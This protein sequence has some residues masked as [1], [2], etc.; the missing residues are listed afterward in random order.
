MFVICKNKSNRCGNA[1]IEVAALGR[2][3]QKQRA[4]WQETLNALASRYTSPTQIYGCTWVLA[5]WMHARENNA[6]LYPWN[7]RTPRQASGLLT[8]LRRLVYEQV[9]VRR[10]RLTT[11]TNRWLNFL[12]AAKQ[13]ATLGSFP[14][15]EWSSP[16][17]RG[18]PMVNGVD[19]RSRATEGTIACEQQLPVS[20]RVE[21]DN[22]HSAL[23]VPVSITASD[24]DY[25]SEYETD[26]ASAIEHFKCAA[27]RE[28]RHLQKKTALGKRFIEV[29]PFSNLRPLLGGTRSSN[30]RLLPKYI[31]PENGRHLF[32]KRDGH[33]HVHRHLVA[34][35]HSEQAGI[36][37]PYVSHGHVVSSA[38]SKYVRHYGPKKL[39][40]YLGLLTARLAI[41]LVILLLLDHPKINVESLIYAELDDENNSVILLSD[42]GD[43]GETT[44]LTVDKPRGKSEKHVL[45]TS[46]GAEIIS[47]VVQ[48]TAA[49]RKHM[50]EEGRDDEARR[51]W[52]GLTLPTGYRVGA[53]SRGMMREAFHRCFSAQKFRKSSHS[54]QKV[55]AHRDAEDF[56]RSHS[57]LSKWVGGVTLKSLRVS[58][59]VLAW[60][61]SGGDVMVAAEMF[62]HKDIMTTLCNY[63]PRALQIAMY[64]REVRRWQNLL[65]VACKTNGNDLQRGT[66]FET[67][68]EF[69]VF[70]RGLFEGAQSGDRD[71]LVGRIQTLINGV[72]S[73]AETPLMCA[74]SDSRAMLIDD[75]LR[76]A[77][78]FLYVDAVRNRAKVPLQG[79]ASASADRAD[80]MW[81]DITD[82]IL[83]PLLDSQRRLSNLAHRSRSLADKQTSQA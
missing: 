2:M 34:Y 17:I 3:P 25:L 13:V 53:L 40:P 64:E 21:Q 30:G 70:L 11:V 71:S 14:K 24:E 1:R 38:V 77:D 55:A 35:I 36:P 78:A 76:L 60:F 80:Q 15:V 42:V 81:V 43:K 32:D 58:S 61:K 39:A 6:R 20:Y 37:E 8:R 59:G 50:R 18:Y 27:Q 33:P 23:L 65:I 73:T 9:S 12:I 5:L 79:L 74:E 19:A 16:G 7:P 10:L 83:A 48:H 75:E 54:R 67:E 63:I 68:A 29:C 41:P 57:A 51:L 69:K 26:L 31:D 66:D 56:V 49:A 82:A 22:F 47:W 44:R 62:G 72:N 52:I 4:A 46:L 45:L 28:F